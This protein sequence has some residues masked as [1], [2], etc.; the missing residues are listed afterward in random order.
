MLPRNEDAETASLFR[1]GTIDVTP[2]ITSP[3]IAA[4]G[5][6]KPFRYQVRASNNPLSFNAFG[7]PAWLNVNTSTGLMTGTPNAEG[8]FTFKLAAYTAYAAAVRDVTI[9]VVDLSDWQ[10]S[11]PI[12]LNYTGNE[13]LYGFPANFKLS[14]DRAP[15]FR[16]SQVASPN[17]RDL[18]FTDEALR[19]IAERAIKR[20]TGARGLRSIVEAILLD[21]MFDLPDMDGVTE[22]VIDKDV[23]E[24]KKEP[25]QVH[26]GKKAEDKEEAA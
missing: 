12:T 26:G 11:M 2:Y 14:E 22:I 5:L 20:K 16:Y 19:A 23:V 9:K 1:Y 8:S 18:R 6:S 4:A 3:E 24:G 15:G 25:I 10:Y 17:G 7:K 21:T 13:N